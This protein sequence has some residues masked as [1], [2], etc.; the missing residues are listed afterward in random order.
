MIYLLMLAPDEPSEAWVEFIRK[1]SSWIY[2]LAAEE[3]SFIH[4]APVRH[5][6]EVAQVWA[7]VKSKDGRLRKS[8]NLPAVMVIRPEDVAGEDGSYSGI[9]VPL[10]S[11]LTVSRDTIERFFKIM[12]DGALRSQK[13][14]AIAQRI[15]SMGALARFLHKGLFLER[16]VS[17]V[18]GLLGT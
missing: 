17:F 6:E 9:T 5:S 1:N 16:L 8:W 12:E 4:N 7:E 2:N 18:R 13:A 15:G 3:A 10:P 14:E 11:G